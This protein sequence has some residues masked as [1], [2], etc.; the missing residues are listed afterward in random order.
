[1]KVWE[2]RQRRICVPRRKLVISGWRILCRKDL[3]DL[4]HSPYKGIPKSFQIHHQYKQPQGVQ[5]SV[6]RWLSI[7]IFWVNLRSSAATTPYNASQLALIAVKLS[8][9]RD[10]QMGNQ[11]IC[12]VLL[13]TWEKCSRNAW[14]EQTSSGDIMKR[15]QTF[16][17]LSQLTK[18]L[19]KN[20]SLQIIP[21]P[22]HRDKNNEMVANSSMK[23]NKISF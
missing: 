14:N 16:E 11:H 13:W 23:T 18:L 6:T 17:W 12:L 4:C 19:L 8:A 7:I 5:L 3:H 10:F 20:E 21:P 9:I 15:T 22:C 1:M 2:L